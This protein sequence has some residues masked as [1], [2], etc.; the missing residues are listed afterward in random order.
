MTYQNT[1]TRGPRISDAMELRLFEQMRM[2]SWRHESMLRSFSG[3]DQ[4]DSEV[5]RIERLLWV[6]IW[7][8]R[9]FDAAFADCDRLWQAYAV[10]QQKKVADAPKT[11]RGPYQGQSVIQHRWVSLEL[12]QTKA[13]HLRT[14][15]LLI[16]GDAVQ[17][18][19][20][21]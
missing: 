6:Q 8:G 15:V 12:W 3:A 13:P 21:A 9:S 16:C 4:A 14:M 5:F 17:H 18:A 10:A 19:E 2:A 20:G 1:N 7:E 11:Q